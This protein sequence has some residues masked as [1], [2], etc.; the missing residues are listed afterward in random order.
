M[1][2][3]LKPPQNLAAIRADRYVCWMANENPTFEFEDLT[4]AKFGRLRVL[5]F[6]TRRARNNYWR[7]E[8]D[9]GAL[10]TAG[11]SNLKSARTLS[12]GCLRREKSTERAHRHGMYESAEYGVWQRIIQRCYNVKHKDYQKFGGRGVGVCPEWRHDFQRFLEEVGPRP[13]DQHIFTLIAGSTE[14]GPQSS[15]WTSMAQRSAA[16]ED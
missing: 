16:K 1:C 10:V 6:A 3:E 7:C 5:S 13:T 4:G 15:A 2:K 12:C 14:F 8:C 9:C 11:A